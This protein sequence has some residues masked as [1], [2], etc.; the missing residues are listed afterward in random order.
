MARFYIILGD[1]RDEDAFRIVHFSLREPDALDERIRETDADMAERF[2][3]AG[4]GA[5]RVLD[6]IRRN[7]VE[8][9]DDT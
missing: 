6:R 9:T 4:G 8:K 3:P 2:E 1:P 5:R 7:C